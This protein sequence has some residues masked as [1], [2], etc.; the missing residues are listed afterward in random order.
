M[1]KKSFFS[2]E[3]EDILRKY[4]PAFGSNECIK[5]INKSKK[6][7]NARCTRLGIK[8]TNKFRIPKDVRDNINKDYKLGLTSK[9][10]SD[11]YRVSIDFINEVTIRKFSER[12]GKYDRYKNEVENLCNTTTLNYIEIGNILGLQAYQ[13]KRIANKF[14]IKHQTI[15]KP[16]KNGGNSRGLMGK[17]KDMYFRSLLE[18]SYMIELEQLGINFNLCERKD[19]HIPYTGIDNKI[20]HYTPDFVVEDSIIEIKP[21]K[22]QSTQTNKLKFIA[23]TNFCNRNNLAFRVIEPNIQLDNIINLY[24]NNAITFSE[25]YNSKFIK[26]CNKRGIIL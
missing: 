22:W 14:K 4:Y 23:A 8:T 16:P 7:I 15:K 10:L 19:I 12:N 18:L 25:Y 9:E 6:Q 5:Y 3:E 24:R 26:Y 13:V 1:S 20:H 21:L 11:K 2:K 17:Y